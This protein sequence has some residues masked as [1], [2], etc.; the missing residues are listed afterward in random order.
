MYANAESFLKQ[1]SEANTADV[2]DTALRKQQATSPVL[3]SFLT[4]EYKKQGVFAGDFNS[5]WVGP[6]DYHF[7]GD[8]SFTRQNGEK[9]AIGEFNTDGGSIPRAFWALPNLSPWTYYPAYVVHDWLYV[10]HHQGTSPYDFG[11]TNLILSEAMWT[12]MVTGLA[13]SSDFTL[14]VVNVA[15]NSVFGRKIW[16]ASAPKASRRANQRS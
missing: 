2:L 7:H 9:I 3:A 15:V 6:R 13:P 11:T 8:C 4:E 5:T 10:L 14:K 12:L 1:L 16:E